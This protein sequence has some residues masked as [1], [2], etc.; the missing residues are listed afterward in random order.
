MPR[1][2]NFCTRPFDVICS[3]ILC[4]LDLCF[5]FCFLSKPEPVSQA[6]LLANRDVQERGCNTSVQIAVASSADRFEILS[7]RS[8]QIPAGEGLRLRPCDRSIAAATGKK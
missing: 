1:A 2:S 3:L 6:S 4:V 7:S 5:L 8:F